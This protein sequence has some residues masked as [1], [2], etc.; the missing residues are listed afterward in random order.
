MAELL[1]VDDLVV[2]YRAMGPA[3]A[4]RRGARSVRRRRARCRSR[5]RPGRRSA[6]SAKRQ[7]QV[8]P[9][10]RDH[11][12][13]QASRRRIHF[14]GMSPS[15]RWTRRSAYRRHRDDVPGPL[16]SLSPRLTVQSLI[17]EPFKIHGL[18]ARDLA[19]EGRAC[20]WSASIRASRAAIRTSSPAVRAPR[21]GRPRT[22]PVAGGGDRRRA[23][24]RA[25]RLGSGRILNLMNRLQR[26][27]GLSCVDHP[28][29]A[30]RTP[31]QRPPGDHVHGPLRR[32]GR[33]EHDLR[34]AGAPVHRGA[35]D[36]DAHT[37]PD[38]RRP[39]PALKGEVPSLLN[40]P[41]SCE[42]HTRC[43]AP[44]AAGSSA[45]CRSSARGQT[46][47]LPSRWRDPALGLAAVAALG[48]MVGPGR[49]RQPQTKPLSTNSPAGTRRS[50]RCRREEPRDRGDRGRS[51]HSA[52]G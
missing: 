13:G 45:R 26:D 27:Q 25:R 28:Q 36:R 5:L 1:R 4:A 18:G 32:A 19:G 6:S 48:R 14:D 39:P 43:A 35:L 46:V 33:H 31:P 8:D 41:S 15:A 3:G 29:P 22:R 51:R 9:R 2:R 42:F 50:G 40:R 34:P 52:R 49:P 12:S 30:G 37:D 23:H 11:G 17:T 10:A 38:R 16:A 7:R 47:P 20:S 44:S 21:R 24:R